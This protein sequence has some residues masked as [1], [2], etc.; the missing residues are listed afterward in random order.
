MNFQSLS[1]QWHTV[2][3][4]STLPKA[5][6]PLARRFA[7][8][9]PGQSV[10]WEK[11]VEGPAASTRGCQDACNWPQS[12]LVRSET[13]AAPVSLAF[14]GALPGLAVSHLL[15]RVG[16]FQPSDASGQMALSYTP[17]YWTLDS[18][19]ATGITNPHC[20]TSLSL[21]LHVTTEG[22]VREKRF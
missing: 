5:H 12:G 6:P 9:L 13:R 1:V 19:H 8:P 3:H 16:A 17:P 10:C 18:G 2:L 4:T 14:S 11:V 15:G 20:L 7:I 22:E 21:V